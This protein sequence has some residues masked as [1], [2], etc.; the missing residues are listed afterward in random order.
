MAMDEEE[1]V[2]KKIVLANSIEDV[3]Y[4]YYQYKKGQKNIYEYLFR[5]DI[6]KNKMLDKYLEH[7]NDISTAV[8]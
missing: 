7:I 8:I 6:T 5:D 3:N 1:L 2:T 4:L